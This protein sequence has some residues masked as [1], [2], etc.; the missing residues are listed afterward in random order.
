MRVVLQHMIR[1]NFS[2]SFLEDSH[3]TI[4]HLESINIE[5]NRDILIILVLILIEGKYIIYSSN[6]NVCGI[7]VHVP[8]M[9]LQSAPVGV[10]TYPGTGQVVT[11]QPLDF[12]L[13]QL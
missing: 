5:I 2:N 6:M 1:R 12:K 13:V 11:S 9:T 3:C 4:L 7:L 10:T 8:K